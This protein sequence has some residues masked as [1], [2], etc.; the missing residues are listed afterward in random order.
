M[1]GV[2]DTTAS[3]LPTRLLD[4]SPPDLPSGHWRLIHASD[5]TVSGPFMTLSHRWGHETF[6]LER[7]TE[8]ALICGMPVTMLP[9]TYRD[10]VQVV[11]RLGVR[12]FWIDSLCI[13]RSLHEWT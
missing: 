8:H 9:G 7:E 13:I 4:L 12:Y 1:G 3:Q 5:K 2:A 11:R 6:K 10:A